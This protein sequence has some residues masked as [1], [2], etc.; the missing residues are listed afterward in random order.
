[1]FKRKYGLFGML[2]MPAHLLM[3]QIL[4]FLFFL[5]IGS[6]IALAVLN[7][8]NFLLIGFLVAALLALF[9]SRSVQAF[10]KTQVTLAVACLKMLRGTETQKFER[11]A[12]VRPD[13]RL[14]VNAD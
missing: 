7:P 13:A 12:S 8:L 4:P 6:F 9:F 5:A 2:I 14:L 1:M 10:A 11:L 3:L